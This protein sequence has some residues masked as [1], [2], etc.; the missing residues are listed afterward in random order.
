M[1]YFEALDIACGEVQ[2]RFDQ[3]DLATVSEIESLLMDAA[4]GKNLEISTIVHD[5]FREKIDLSR[6]KVQLQ[7]LPD[8]LKTAFAGSSSIKAVTSVRTIAEAL[9]QSEVVKGMLSEVDKVLKAYL[10]RTYVARRARYYA[11]F[12]LRAITRRLLGNAPCPQ[13]SQTG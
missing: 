9:N 11:V 13:Q 12:T 1:T 8:A 3:S 5:F 6:F 10:T 2:R 4:N 7:M